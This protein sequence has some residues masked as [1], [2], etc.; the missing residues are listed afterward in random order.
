MDDFKK[1]SDLVADEHQT[2]VLLN[3]GYAPEQR[4]AGQWFEV[5]P[6]LYDY[7]LGVLPP[8]HFLGTAFVV[9]EAATDTLSDAFVM[10]EGRGFC[11]SVMNTGQ[12]AFQ[13]TV[14]EFCA[15]VRATSTARVTA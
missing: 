2:F 4:S 14:K 6:R 9:A 15:H 10:H 8:K 13:N 12:M 1:I 3:R 5:E 7:F 11:L